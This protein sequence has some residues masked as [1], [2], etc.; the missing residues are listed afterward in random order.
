MKRPPDSTARCTTVSA[1]LLRGARWDP[2]FWH[3]GREELGAVCCV[4][5]APLGDFIEFITYGPILPGRRPEP[6]D[7][8]VAIV[9]QSEI[10]PTGLLLDAATAVAEGSPYDPP[11]R[12]LRPGD[13]V[14]ARSGVGTLA[15]KRFTVFALPVKATVSCFVDLI[16]LRGISPYG[17]ATFLRSGLG[18]A[19]IERQFRGVGTPNLNFAQIRS[20]RVPL[21]PPEAERAVEAAWADVAR[22]HAAGRFAEAEARLDA[23]AA[24]LERR[25]REARPS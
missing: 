24:D 3:P 10:R 14:L 8:G 7:E 13:L 25:L 20:L 4:P 9:G 1:R 15:R 19:Q 23:A 12:R 11:R 22:L 18:W 5:L 2:A 6:A 16:R 17:V 21:L